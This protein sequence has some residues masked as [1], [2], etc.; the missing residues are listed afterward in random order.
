MR[1][2]LIVIGDEILSGRRQDGHLPFVVQRLAGRGQAL[3]WAEFVADER[4]ALTETLARA[5][6]R[7]RTGGDVVFCCG[8]IGSTPD[9]HTRQCAAAALGVPL[10]PHPEAVALI[11]ARIAQR[12]AEQGIPFDPDSPGQAVRRQMGHFPQ[13][14][15]ILP[16]PFN[17]I[18]GF[19]VGD[20]HFMPG[21]PVMAHPMMDGLLATRY[22]HL[23]PRDW[24]EHQL[25]ATRAFEADLTPLMQRIEA[26]HP[27]VRVFSL[28]VVD[29][30]HPRGP[31]VE[32]GVKGPAAD[33]ALAF[34][35]L[36]AGLDAR[37]TPYQLD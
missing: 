5:F 29:K 21:F 30:A 6:Q 15:A 20:V 12:C 13:G 3:A 14:A 26:D 22:A 18:P 31:H 32:L 10:V 36:R 23:A 33:A 4:P 35:A 37:A 34:S 25:Y 17:Q 2:G 27:T 16:N 7:S 11:D 19:S 1:F 24:A 8:G 28:P 9:D